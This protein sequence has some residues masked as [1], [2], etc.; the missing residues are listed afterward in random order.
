MVETELESCPRCKSDAVEWTNSRDLDVLT[1]HAYCTN[2]ELS[3]FNVETSAFVHL[4]SLDYETT[5]M[6]YNKWAKTNPKS[7]HE[8]NWE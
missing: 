2:C 4:P 7:W 6:K 8:D 5:V 1:S 3:T